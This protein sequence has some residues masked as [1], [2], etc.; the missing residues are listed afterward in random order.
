MSSVQ[1]YWQPIAVPVYQPNASF[2][3]IPVPGAPTQSAPS[4]TPPTFT[5]EVDDAPFEK[6][7]VTPVQVDYKK[8]A[9]EDSKAEEISKKPPMDISCE[10]RASRINEKMKAVF[11]LIRV[12]MYD[13][14]TPTPEVTPYLERC[15]KERPVTN[16]TFIAVVTN[17]WG[18]MPAPSSSRNEEAGETVMRWVI[19]AIL[20]G[21][22]V[23]TTYF[24]M[25]DVKKNEYTTE[26]MKALNELEDEIVELEKFNCDTSK[27]R[28]LLKAG[29]TFFNKQKVDFRW[30]VITKSAVLAACIA[31]VVGVAVACW[32]AVIAGLG[33]LAIAT[34]VIVGRIAY[35]WND[36]SKI[37]HLARTILSPFFDENTPIPVKM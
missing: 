21:I 5:G 35:T 33:V 9:L 14:Y 34:V 30:S 26:A 31:G 13:Y 24:L 25:K 32:P 27:P 17:G 37:S 18:Y 12:V 20:V 16:F 15:P 28:N 22:A 2:A 1:P 23:V 3:P 4:N 7:K 10:R 8:P 6:V 36:D 11:D 19:G 29:D